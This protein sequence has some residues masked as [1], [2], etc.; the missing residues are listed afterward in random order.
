L[1]FWFLNPLIKKLPKTIGR[2]SACSCR[3]LL[4]RIN[5]KIESTIP[6]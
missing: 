1:Q 5:Q 6:I 2:A 3:Y 4:H